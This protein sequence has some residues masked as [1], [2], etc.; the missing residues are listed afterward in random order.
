MRNLNQKDKLFGSSPFLVGKSLFLYNIFMET[1]NSHYEKLLNI[2]KPWSIS[3]IEFKDNKIYM[4]VEYQKREEALCPVCGELCNQYDHRTIRTWRHSDIME[5]ESYLTCSIPRID[6]KKDGIKTINIPFAPENSHFTFSF[7]NLVLRDLESTEAL[8]NIGKRHNISFKQLMLI[9]EKAVERGL[10]RRELEEVEKLGIDEKSFLRNHKY[11]TT[12]F[13]IS[14][15]KALEVVEGRT[16]ESTKNGL[17]SLGDSIKTVRATCLD[18]WKP[19]KKAVNEII[20]GS[21]IVYDRFHVMLYLNKAVDQT[22]RRE[23]ILL[24]LEDDT[25]LTHTKFLWLKKESNWTEYDKA[26]FE[27]LEHR[28]FQ[29]SKAWKLKELFR[30]FYLCDTKEKAN[31]FFKNW[32]FL[33]THSRIKYICDVAW[34]LKKHIDGLLNFI[35]WRITNS[36]AESLNSIIQS[37]KANAKGF[38]NFKNYR[39][40][41]L[42]VLGKLDVSF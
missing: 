34:M 5:Y 38:R 29:V 13:D 42:F 16:Y 24:K 15:R 8:M 36:I 25:S 19:F 22:R 11:I 4:H 30:E 6:C 2:E 26:K 23:H 32:F 37:I 17:I 7:L 10:L 41:I 3:S 40:R 12:F 31:S 14:E 9:Q 39:T 28:E 1:I 18:M 20:P 27:A 33:A 21:D 35:D